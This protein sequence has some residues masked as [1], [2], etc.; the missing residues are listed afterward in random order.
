M[1]ARRV[2]FSNELGDQWFEMRVFRSVPW[3][4]SK[5][6]QAAA[7]AQDENGE[8]TDEAKIGMA[9]VI[10]A[11]LVTNGHVLNAWTGEPMTFPLSSESVQEAPVELLTE[12][13]RVFSE[14][15]RG[16]TDPKSTTA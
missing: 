11:A 8:M 10:A 1:N 16:D 15:K 5:K 4:L 3:G 2:E 7:G 13:L 6:L 12:V 14:M 9:E